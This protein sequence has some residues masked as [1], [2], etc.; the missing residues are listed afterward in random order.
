[1]EGEHFFKAEVLL[2]ADIFSYLVFFFMMMRKLLRRKH[3]DL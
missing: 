2:Y 1:M 3:D